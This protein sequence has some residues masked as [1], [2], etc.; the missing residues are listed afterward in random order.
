MAHPNNSFSMGIV[1]A[2][3]KHT[4][5][6]KDSIA[7]PRTILVIRNSVKQTVWVFLLLYLQDGVNVL[8]DVISSFNLSDIASI[9]KQRYQG[10]IG[11]LT[12]TAKSS[13]AFPAMSASS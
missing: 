1:H 10:L 4:N 11:E 9:A 3:T 12:A 2:S 6:R 8:I 7:A 5:S 13:I